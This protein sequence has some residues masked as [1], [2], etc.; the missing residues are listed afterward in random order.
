MPK[1]L[2]IENLEC[3]QWRQ[4]IA[5]GDFKRG[6]AYA[7]QGRSSVLQLQGATVTAQCKGSAG[8]TYLQTITLLDKSN[9]YDI[10]LQLVL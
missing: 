6:K 4:A 3:A 2:N 10:N 7:D 9:Y 1:T 8:Q 5:L